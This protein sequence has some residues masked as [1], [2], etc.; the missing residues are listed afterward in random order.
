MRDIKGLLILSI[1]LL[2]VFSQCLLLCSGH[3]DDEA[4]ATRKLG[5]FIRRRARR[6]RGHRPT[7]ASTT[8]LSG[9]FH[10]TACLATSFLLSLLI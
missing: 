3:G 2:L 4:G 7:S 8:L 5:V 9:S 6:F 10:M 1:I